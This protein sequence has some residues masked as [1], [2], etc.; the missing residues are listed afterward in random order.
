ML[1]TFSATNESTGRG[2]LEDSLAS[3]PERRSMQ[4]ESSISNVFSMI[5]AFVFVFSWMF[6]CR[7]YLPAEDPRLVTCLVWEKYAVFPGVM[8]K[9]LFLNRS[10]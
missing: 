2:I 5:A 10:W 8:M 7:G 3:V 6:R 1:I 4:L 9:G